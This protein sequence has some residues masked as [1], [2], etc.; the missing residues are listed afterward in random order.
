MH[1]I[2]DSFISDSSIFN[3]INTI[4]LEL[5][6]FF[7]SIFAVLVPREI[8]CMN[9]CPPFWGPQ[10]LCTREAYSS[11]TFISQRII[12]LSH[13][14]YTACTS[15]LISKLHQSNKVNRRRD[16]FDDSALYLNNCSLLPQVLQVQKFTYYW[17]VKDLV[18]I[19]GWKDVNFPGSRQLSLVW[20]LERKLYL[21]RHLHTTAWITHKLG[22]SLTIC[23]LD[24]VAH[25]LFH[26]LLL[27]WFSGFLFFS[28]FFF[29]MVNY[30]SRKCAQ[31][32]KQ[33]TN[34]WL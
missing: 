26:F 32:W 29:F 1:S 34:E 33:Q 18:Q 11:W 6:I 16:V 23:S 28:F 20:N 4:S 24:R 17:S 22:L 9:G 10:G 13:Q 12:H 30:W 15:Y 25:Q 27:C 19:L 8:T 5:F 3:V 31:I 7:P 21:S 2:E 14:R